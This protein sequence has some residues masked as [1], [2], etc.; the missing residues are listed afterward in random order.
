MASFPGGVC[1]CGGDGTRRHLFQSPLVVVLGAAQRSWLG[2]WD[3]KPILTAAFAFRSP[4][5]AC[6]EVIRVS[7]LRSHSPLPQP[8]PVRGADSLADPAF[9]KTPGP[10]SANRSALRRGRSM[11]AARRTCGAA[12]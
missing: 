2:D 9:A 8:L 7:S 12:V 10:A 11:T 4:H 5:Y 1:V 3:T 6:P